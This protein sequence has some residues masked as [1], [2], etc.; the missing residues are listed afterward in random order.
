MLIMKS[1]YRKE[2]IIIKKYDKLNIIRDESLRLWDYLQEC[3]DFIENK[4]YLYDC[5]DTNEL[6]AYSKSCR[7]SYEN[8]YKLTYDI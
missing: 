6:L 4:Y 7:E 1:L 3:I 2:V 8:I 5:F